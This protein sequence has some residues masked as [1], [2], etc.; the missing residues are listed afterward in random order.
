MKKLV[1]F[2]LSV[3]VLLF[4]SSC[5]KLEPLED[6]YNE[7]EFG[8]I[9]IGKDEVKIMQITDLHLTYG[10]DALD[11]KTYK[12][13]EALVNQEK[14]DLIVLTGDL[15]MSVYGK[16]I[17]KK[18]IKFMESLKVPWSYTFGNHE[19]EYHKMEQ[20]VDII[21]KTKTEYL[22]F[23]YGPKLTNDN[24][25]GYSNYKLKLTNGNYPILNLY[26]LDTKMNRTDGVI[27][28]DYPYDYLTNEQVEWFNN[29]LATDIVS[30]LA[31]MHIPLQQY[32]LYGGKANEKVWAQGEDTGFFQTILNNNKKTLGIFV[33]HDHL[34]NHSFYLEEILLAYG[35]SSGFNAYGSQESKGARIITYNYQTNMLDT[36]IVYNDE[37]LQ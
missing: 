11:R 33:G 16:Q 30:S 4:V 12:L 14:P 7:N 2:I 25:H 6:N 20:I 1:T 13:I 24:T 26:L 32:E 37:V 19:G 27:S 28:D 21:L 35:I 17:L 23:H 22:Y 5:S 18:F 31:F 10:F 3:I 15:F 29:N 9:D 36:Y 34:N 8:Y